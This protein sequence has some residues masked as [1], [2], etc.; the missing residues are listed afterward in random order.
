MGFSLWNQPVVEAQAGNVPE[1]G[2]IVRDQRQIVHQRH[3]G[4]HQVG[5]GDLDAL[6]QQQAANLAELVRARRVEVNYGNVSKQIGNK[7]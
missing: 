6:P 7:G 4:D 1:I 5:S 3:R 2:G